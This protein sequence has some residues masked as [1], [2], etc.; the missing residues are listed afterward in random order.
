MKSV[1]GAGLVIVGFL[2][3][4]MA[5]SGRLDCLFTFFSCVTGG[6]TTTPASVS[7]SSQTGASTGV[8]NTPGTTTWLNGAAS[9]G[10]ILQTFN[11]PALPNIPKISF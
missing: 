8:V 9:I 11:L 10:N 6:V 2:F 7:G 5:I 1:G 4:W 3:I